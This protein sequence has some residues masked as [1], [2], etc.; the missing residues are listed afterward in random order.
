MEEMPP[1]EDQIERPYERVYFTPFE[2]ENGLFTFFRRGPDFE[3]VQ[4]SNVDWPQCQQ[5]GT[6]TLDSWPA[7][8]TEDQMI[9]RR[10]NPFSSHQFPEQCASYVCSYTPDPDPPFWSCHSP[11]YMIGS[12]Q[13][14][15]ANT[16]IEKLSVD[17]S[18]QGLMSFRKSTQV[19]ELDSYPDATLFIS[20]TGLD[21]RVP[22]DL[23]IRY[24]LPL[25]DW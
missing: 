7:L 15:G 6:G 22:C 12:T 11:C 18:F 3:W 8:D 9:W 1:P 10:T 13:C 20:M 14:G 5:D 2:G 24:S 4:F 25:W 16:C 21:P 19:L 23:E 17:W